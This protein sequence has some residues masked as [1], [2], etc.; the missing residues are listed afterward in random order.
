MHFVNNSGKSGSIEM[1]SN[2]IDEKF[3]DINM[4]QYSSND[5][6]VSSNLSGLIGAIA[7]GNAKNG[8]TQPSTHDQYL[9]SG[10]ET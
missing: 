5:N 3:S 6:A 1:I 7:A 9:S 2:I 10:D 4:S 8:L